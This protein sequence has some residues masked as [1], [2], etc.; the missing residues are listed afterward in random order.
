MAESESTNYF[1]PP[2]ADL[3]PD[4][5]EDPQDHPDDAEI[6]RRAYRKYE[7][8]VIAVGNLVLCAA[9]LLSIGAM[10]A[11]YGAAIRYMF[12]DPITISTIIVFYITP[13]MIMYRLGIGLRRLDPKSRVMVGISNLIILPLALFIPFLLIPRSVRWVDY[14]VRLGAVTPFAFLLYLMH[15]VIRSEAV[16]IF[17]GRYRRSIELTPH[18]ENDPSMPSVVRTTALYM[19]GAITA[20]GLFFLAV[21]K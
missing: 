7:V 2:K 21:W 11:V 19:V 9:A 10:I 3:S 12:Y 15:A 1:E 6:V 17:T 4:S 8:R 16:A 5:S 14:L 20:I 13:I 18:V